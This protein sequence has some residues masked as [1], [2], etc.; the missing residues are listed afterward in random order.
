M[1]LNEAREKG[2]VWVRK[3]QW[4]NPQARVKLDKFGEYYGPWGHLY[5]EPTQTAIGVPIPQDFLVLGDTAEDWEP[6]EE[7][8]R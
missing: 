8:N 6:Y 5:D 3:P 4:A 7:G 2:L 1:T